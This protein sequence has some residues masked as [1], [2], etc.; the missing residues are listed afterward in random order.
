[1]YVILNATVRNVIMMVVTAN[2]PDVNVT[3]P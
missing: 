1:M 2:I 3:K